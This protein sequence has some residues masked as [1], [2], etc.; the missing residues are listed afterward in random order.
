MEFGEYLKQLRETKNLS[1]RKLD[2]LSGVSYV[3]LSQIENGKRGIPSP[4]VLKKL[5]APLGVSYKELMQAAGYLGQ[6]PSN[7]ASIFDIQEEWPEIAA[8][9]RKKMTPEE[10]RRVVRI[11]KAAIP[12]DDEE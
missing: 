1:F 7:Q 10:K 4:D 8:V 11:I 5:A 3:Y 9:L 6:D 2:A 12:A